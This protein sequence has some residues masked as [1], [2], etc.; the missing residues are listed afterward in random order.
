MFIAKICPAGDRRWVHRVA[1]PI[2][3][4]G[5]V[6]SGGVGQDSEDL[7]GPGGDGALHC[8]AFGTHGCLLSWGPSRASNPTAPA[9]RPRFPLS[10]RTRKEPLPS[11]GRLVGHRGEVRSPEYFFVARLSTAAA[12]GWGS[13]SSVL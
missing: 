9:E 2:A 6:V 13:A 11:D 5:V 10:P 7:L 12:T 3:R 1:N 4:F 8:V